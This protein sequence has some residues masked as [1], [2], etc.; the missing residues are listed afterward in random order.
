MIATDKRVVIQTSQRS[1]APDLV[2][3][4]NRSNHSNYS[5]H[6]RRSALRKELLNSRFLSSFKVMDL[7]SMQSHCY[8]EENL[9]SSLIL[10]DVRRVLYLIGLL[11]DVWLCHRVVVAI[12]N[13]RKQIGRSTFSLVRRKVAFGRERS[14]VEVC[15]EA[16]GAK[17]K[18]CL[19]IETRS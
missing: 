15:G 1:M 8:P 12:Q 18:R 10:R 14:I 13:L 16:S 19:L 5:N 2:W 3:N 7:F 17:V 11:S 9:T 4:S 6:S